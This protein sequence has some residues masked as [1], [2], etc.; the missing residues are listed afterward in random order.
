MESENKTHGAGEC[1]FASEEEQSENKIS[2]KL[3]DFMGVSDVTIECNNPPKK[4]LLFTQ[5]Q[6]FHLHNK[7][8]ATALVSAKIPWSLKICLARLSDSDLFLF[9]KSYFF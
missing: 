4:L 7:M 5:T 1:S 9:T 2:K 3:E 8:Q 6:V